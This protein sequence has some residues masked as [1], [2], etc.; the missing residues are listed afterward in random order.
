MRNAYKILVGKPEGKKKLG[1]LRLRW[2]DNIKID[3]REIGFGHVDCIHQIG[4]G[5]V[6]L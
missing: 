3:F 1:S 6:L 5:G 2:A 4:I